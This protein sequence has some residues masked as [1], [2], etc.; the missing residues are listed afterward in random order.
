MYCCKT[1]EFTAADEARKCGLECHMIRKMWEMRLVNK[2]LNDVG[3]VNFEDMGQIEKYCM[4]FR[5]RIQ[6]NKQQI[7][8]V[9]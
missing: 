1:W 8:Q 6:A 4:E 9:K 3:F 2:V 7:T 5:R